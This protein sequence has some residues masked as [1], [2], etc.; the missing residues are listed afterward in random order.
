MKFVPLVAFSGPL[1]DLPLR[2]SR[3]PNQSLFDIPFEPGH[4][5]VVY[6]HLRVPRAAVYHCI[7]CGRAGAA[8]RSSI[9][10]LHS[11]Q[12]YRDRRA[13]VSSPP[14]AARWQTN[15][16]CT[17]RYFWWSRLRVFLLFAQEL[18]SNCFQAFNLLQ[19]SQ[20]VVNAGP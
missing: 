11:G 9:Y 10:G 17:T 19:Y 20:N 2:G 1:Y 12:I 16:R 5:L 15:S 8:A 4:E 6:I 13:T 14:A 7:S 3:R 18:I